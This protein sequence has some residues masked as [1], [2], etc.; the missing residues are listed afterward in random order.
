[1]LFRSICN[2][3]VNRKLKNR[4]R[5]VID[6]EGYRK[7]REQTLANLAK[8]LAARVKETGKKVVLEPMNAQERRIIHT[9]LQNESN[10]YTA[11]EGKEPYRKVVINLRN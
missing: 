9:T 7:R 3:A 10:I 2:L 11:S 8:R 6:I 5:I 4:I 1:M